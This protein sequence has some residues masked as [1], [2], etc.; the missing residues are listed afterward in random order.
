MLLLIF[1]HS[2]VQSGD[3][4][5]K[6]VDK[7]TVTSSPTTTTSTAASPNAVSINA[8]TSPLDLARAALA[9]QGGDKFR[10]MKNMVL[11]GSVSLYSPGTTQSLTGK[12]GIIYAGEQMRLEVQTPMINFQLINDGQHTYT[13]LRAIDMPPPSKF[14][15]PV[16]AKFDQSGY[17]VSAIP[18]KKKQRGFRITDADGNVTDY[19]IDTATARVVRYEIPYNNLNFIV[20]HTTLKEVDGILVP[21]AFVQ[22]LDTT[23]GAYYAE[24]KVK[25]AKVNQTLPDNTFAIPGQ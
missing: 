1:V 3:A 14:G 8:N 15:M 20:E 9:A 16:L 24:F 11:L 6:P 18:D 17:T 2:F 12:F 25:E 7:T 22:K 10:R 23:N 19:Y 4:Q 21:L 5:Q 13:S